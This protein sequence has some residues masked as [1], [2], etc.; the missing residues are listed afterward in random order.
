MNAELEELDDIVSF[1][2]DMAVCKY[3]DLINR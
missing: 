3:E 2:G 1:N